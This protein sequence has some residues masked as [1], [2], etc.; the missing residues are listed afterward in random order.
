MVIGCGKP[1]NGSGCTIA[2]LFPKTSCWWTST[3]L[4]R[5]RRRDP[6]PPALFCGCPAASIRTGAITPVLGGVGPMT[7]MS[8]MH[9]SLIA[10]SMQSG[11]GVP[12]LRQM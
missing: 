4:Q 7:I 3:G 9:N 11:L 6:G 1:R 10:A 2:S 12:L 5:L 8:L